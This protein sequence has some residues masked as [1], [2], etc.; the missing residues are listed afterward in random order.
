MEGL[1]E[2]LKR[3]VPAI[4]WDTQQENLLDDGILDSIDVISIVAELTT[5]FGIEIP[6]EEMEEDNFQS[7]QAMADMIRRIQEEE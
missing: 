7:V 5:E 1:L 3:A 2:A 6:P 4:D